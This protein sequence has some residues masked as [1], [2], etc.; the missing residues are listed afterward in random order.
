MT[1]VLQKNNQTQKSYFRRRFVQNIFENR[2]L[3]ILLFVLQL[4]GLPVISFCGQLMIK[5]ETN[6]LPVTNTI[7]IIFTAF[8][9]FAVACLL[10]ISSAISMFSYLVQKSQTDTVLSLPIRSTTR[11]CADYLSGLLIYI[12]PYIVSGMICFISVAIGDKNSMITDYF[13]YLGYYLDSPDI[14]L[15]SFLAKAFIIG[16]LTML[17]FYNI[18]VFI[19]TCCGTIKEAVTYSLVTNLAIPGIIFTTGLIMYEGL[20]SVEPSVEILDKLIVSSPFGGVLFIISSVRYRIPFSSWLPGFLLTTILFFGASF[21]LYKKRKAEDVTKPFVF[22][23]FYYVLLCSAVFAASGLISQLESGIP[24]AAPIITGSVIFIGLDLIKN[25]GI[26]S[27]RQ[28]SVSIVCLIITMTALFSLINA[29]SKTNGFNSEERIPKVSQISSVKIDRAW[30]NHCLYNYLEFTDPDIFDEITDIH[31]D[32]IE[33]LKK[34]HERKQNH[35]Q[36]DYSP[37]DYITIQYTLKNGD[38]I[39]R[40]YFGIPVDNDTIRKI[41]SLITDNLEAKEQLIERFKRDIWYYYKSGQVPYNNILHIYVA[42]T[43]L[44]AHLRYQE[45]NT[46]NIERIITEICEAYEKDI[47]SLTEKAKFSFV[48]YEINHRFPIPSCFTNTIDAIESNLD[49]FTPKQVTHN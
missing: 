5:Q 11:F 18:A 29:S 33:G 2:K 47:M 16:L 19:T 9:L 38:I 45:Y 10:G 43:D 13:Y 14:P 21:F 8:L 12:V 28:V 48:P 25:K 41:D 30:L 49:Y 31:A 6:N 39:S 1:Q 42:D 24:A 35:K 20:E 3:T 7:P 22:Q 23:F 26:K 46:E 15:L 40:D 36:Y 44:N 17:M 37:I 32:C 34:K 4:S 27:I